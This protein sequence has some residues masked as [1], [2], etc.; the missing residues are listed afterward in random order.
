MLFLRYVFSDTLKQFYDDRVIRQLGKTVPQNCSR[1]QEIVFHHGALESTGNKVSSGGILIGVI[2]TAK[3]ILL[4]NPNLNWVTLVS[5][6]P[7]QFI[8]VRWFKM[9]IRWKFQNNL[10]SYSERSQDCSLYLGGNRCTKRHNHN[11]NDTAYLFPLFFHCMHSLTS[12]KYFLWHWLVS[13]SLISSFASYEL[14]VALNYMNYIP[15]I[16]GN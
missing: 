5:T 15:S 2:Y 11:Q 16:N 14:A 13:I 10:G 9:N 7:F 4:S 8:K 3:I 12:N 6:T 1:I